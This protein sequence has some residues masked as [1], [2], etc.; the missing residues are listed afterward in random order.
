[1]RSGGILS[2][3]DM[4]VDIDGVARKTDIGSDLIQTYIEQGA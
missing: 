2:F 4:Y 3:I 1:M